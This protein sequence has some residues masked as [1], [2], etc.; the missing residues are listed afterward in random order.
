MQATIKVES[1]IDKGTRFIIKL[2]LTIS[3]H[4]DREKIT[5]RVPPVKQISRTLSISSSK[6]NEPKILENTD[7][8]ARIL[9]VEDNPVA[10]R[11]IQ[12]S[13]KRLYSHCG[14][15]FAENGEQAFNM[16]K[17]N[18]YDLILMDV[19]LGAGPDGIEVT[20]RIRALSSPTHAQV[21]IVAITGH[22][23]DPGKKEEAFAAGMQEVFAKPLMQP[24]LESLIQRFVFNA[25][26]EPIKEAHS[27]KTN[28]QSIAHIVDWEQCIQLLGDETLIREL[29]A[30]LVLDLQMSKEQIA[31]TYAPMDEEALRAELHRVRAG[32]VYLSLPQLLQTHTAFHEA[33]KAKPQQVEQ[34]EKTYAAFLEAIKIFSETVKMEFL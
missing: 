30:D 12:S 34:L 17:E 15:E 27:S 11:A 5:Y 9:I 2:P 14:C 29:L 22:A 28:L 16:A 25:K 13:I 33:V 7:A 10:A 20:R 23:D 8:N 4:S 19:G 26:K 31:K 1:E 24:T 21:P 6:T 3:D 18:D 32:I